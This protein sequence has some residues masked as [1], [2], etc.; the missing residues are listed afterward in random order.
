M[1]HL[2]SIIFL[3]LSLFTTPHILAQV[4]IGSNIKP[5]KGSILDIKE[6]QPTAGD[7][8]QTTANRGLLMPRVTLLSLTELKPMYSYADIE[9]TPSGID[10]QMHIGLIVYNIIQEICPG[11]DILEG[12]YVWQ[13][14]EWKLLKNGTSSNGVQLFKDQGGNTFK[15]RTFGDAGTWMVDNLAVK[16][17]SDNTTID[18]FNGNAINPPPKPMYAYPS[19]TTTGWNSQPEIWTRR[20]GLLYNWTAA[21]NNYNPGDIDQ[22]QIA[23]SIPG[24]NEVETLQE[25]SEGAKN[26]KIQGICPNGWHIPSDR[27]WNALEKELYNNPEKYSSYTT[28]EIGTFIP[29]SWQDGW[30]TASGRRPSSANNTGHGAVMKS[31]CPPADETAST[32]GKS[33]LNTKGGFDAILLGSISSTTALGYGKSGFFWTSSARSAETSMQRNLSYNYPTISRSAGSKNVFFS[34]RCKKN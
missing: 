7:P 11:T 19:R 4:T 24:A 25:N 3:M 32:G 31:I 23:G 13:G 6:R 29:N 18:I 26:G 5:N 27:E 16:H 21:T 22:S 10:E 8:D 17:Y 12:L 34:V 28:D 33:H 9:N 14:S 30:E 20:Q 15:A 1:L 2:R